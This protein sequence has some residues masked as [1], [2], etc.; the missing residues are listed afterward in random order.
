[1]L[2][3]LR[4]RLRALLFKSRMENELEEEVKF[5]LEKEIEQNLA[6]GL[7]P[8]DARLAALRSFGGVERIKEESRDVR[9]VRLVEELWQDL[10]Y[11]A[12]M[13]RKAP[14]FTLVAMLTLGLGIG[15]NAAIFSLIDTVFLKPL[16]VQDPGRLILLTI[17][18][19][20][21]SGASFPYPTYAQFRDRV[22]S[23]SDLAASG[24]VDRLKIALSE[25]GAGGQVESVQAETVSGNFFSAL[26][27]NAVHGRVLTAEDDRAENP[28]ASVVISY[29]FWRRRFGLDQAVVGKNIRLKDVP[30]TIV[31]VAPPGFSGFEVGRSPDLWWPLQMTPRLYPGSRILN[32][33]SS[34]WLRLMGRL[35][36]GRNEAQAHA[37]LDLIFRPALAE[38][39]ES[40]F[41]A[42]RTPAERRNFLERKIELQ[43]GRA[44]WTIL[45]KRLKQPLLILMTMVALALA[46][47]CANV[48]NLLL[49]R[50]AG[51][52]PEIAMRLALGA[53]RMRLVRQLLTESALL[54]LIGGALGLLFAEWGARLLLAYLPSPSDL[55][56][57]FAPDSRVLGFTLAISMLTG[58]LFGLAPALRAARFD[59]VSMLKDRAIGSGKVGSRLSL[60]KALVA[61]Q[62][63]LSLYL[64]VGAGLFARSLQ[65]L[66]SIDAGFDRENVV[67]FSL[68]TDYDAERRADLYQ[69]LLDRLAAL[70][71]ALSAS[72]SSHGLLLNDTWNNNVTVEGRASRF[73]EDLLCYGQVVA[74]RFFETMG[75]P[76]LSGRD[77]G[78]QDARTSGPDGGH[79]PARVA[80]INQTM[81]RYFFPNENP[82]GKRFSV[83]RPGELIEVVGVVKDAKYETL[84]EEPLRI[85]YLP[86]FQGSSKLD[87]T[88]HVRTVGQPAGMLETIRR[89][90]KELDPNA[91]ALRMR[92]MNDVVDESLARERFLAQFAGF[93]SLFAALLAAIGLY[94][95][96]SYAVTRRTNEI[97]VRM[98]LGA[99]APDVI[100]MIFQES[101]PPVVIGVAIGLGAALGSARYVASLLYGLSPTDPATVSLA[102]LGMLVV[103]ALASYW[104][105]RRASQL[106]PMVALRRE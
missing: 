50:A 22:S 91:P 2:K 82:I 38:I 65:K 43:P 27:V 51:R 98:A 94:G 105:A 29:G 92:T 14:G 62:V 55:S 41:G 10:R 61:T 81:A 37:E 11:G 44:G 88:F 74:P 99:R 40:E 1:M 21:S 42:N 68:D 71:G 31:G 103:A 8:E 57:N 20:G 45:R 77:F 89:A 18:D 58:L 66:K 100:R 12:R 13:L 25:P 19:H 80:L 67:L 28:Q 64:L 7:S 9:G 6:R 76:I 16:P 54:A 46:V 34:W 84:R 86:F 47:A 95:V 23:F 4:L 73:D 39:A 49:A 5:H 104:P 52:V 97:G 93:F 56:F 69:R 35:R 102:A 70:P 75:I 87:T 63:A 30:F 17:D 78:P 60:N 33:R 72:L 36:P 96:L 83:N 106:D 26:G 32:A 48:A 85:F 59:L 90:A 53:G 79:N 24:G 3:K 101:M 15:A